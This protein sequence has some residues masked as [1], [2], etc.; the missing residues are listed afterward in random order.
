[1]A[2]LFS[3]GHIRA[4][5]F[6]KHQIISDGAARL[7]RSPEFQARLRVLRQTIQA[8]HAG[9]FAQAGFFRRQVL[10]W[11]MAV[12]FRRERRTLVPSAHSLYSSRI[13]A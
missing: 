9:E 6:M 5:D 7:Q 13:A 4:F 10:R 3:L 8:R 12:E 11:Q 1:V 2:Q